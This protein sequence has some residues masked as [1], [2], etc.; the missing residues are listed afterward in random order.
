[1]TENMDELNRET[2]EAW[3][4][5][6]DVWDNRMGDKGNDFFNILCWPALTSLL[7][8][9]PFR[10][11]ATSLRKRLKSHNFANLRTINRIMAA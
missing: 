8:A 3:E 10:D 7:D 2:H 11:N 4:V 1:M 5:N 9:S 6:A